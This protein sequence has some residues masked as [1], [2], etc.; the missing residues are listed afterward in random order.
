MTAPSH[1]ARQSPPAGSFKQADGFPTTIAFSSNPAIQFWEKDVKPP[2]RDGGDG[3]D[4]TSMLNTKYRTQQPPTLIS[5]T[6]I[7]ANVFYDPDIFQSGASGV[8]SLIN[9]NQSITVFFPTGDYVDFYGWL[10]D[11][12]PQDNKEKE[13]PMA[14][15]TIKISN[16][17]P[18]NNVEQGPVYTAAS[19]E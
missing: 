15:V 12:T 8:E 4:T 7:T 3:I 18:T 2:G 14:Q 10:K 1:T 16:W 17:D 13:A 5:T 6:D 9:K 11:F 19:P